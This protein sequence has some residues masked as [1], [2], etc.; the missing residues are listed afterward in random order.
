M[1]KNSKHVADY[2]NELKELGKVISD[3]VANLEKNRAEYTLLTRQAEWHV[4]GLIYHAEKLTALYKHVASEVGG[5]HLSTK[6]EYIIFHSEELQELTFEFY[7]FV[8]LARLSLDELKNCLKPLF[9]SNPQLPNSITDVL[10]GSTDCPLYSGLQQGQP[11]LRYL[12]DIRDCIVHHRTFATSHDAVAMAKEAEEE[13]FAKT[14]PQGWQIPVTR[15]YF[16]R[17]T[18][19]K[20]VVNILLPDAIYEVGQDSHRGKMVPHFTYDIGVNILA[21]SMEFLKLCTYET[22]LALN[23]LAKESKQGYTWSKT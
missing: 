20:L 21:Q 15:I 17:D 14:L 1:N 9:T 4:K 22:A 7:A 16:N 5:R 3:A 8:L 12:I 10:K 2:D 11:I 13:N 18:L 19:G 23:L 6:A